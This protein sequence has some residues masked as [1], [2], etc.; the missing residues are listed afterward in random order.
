[1]KEVAIIGAG[2]AGLYL[3]CR[4]QEEGFQ[5][6]VF[7]KESA[8][9]GLAQCVPLEGTWIEKYYHHFFPNHDRARALVEELGL[10]RDL[11]WY[12]TRMGLY[13]KGKTYYF[14]GIKDLL[15]FPHHRS[16]EKIN[17]LYQ[18]A[19]IT[20]KKD[21]RLG[22]VSVLDFLHARFSENT[23]ALLWLPLLKMKFGDSYPDIAAA[24]LTTRI[25][26]RKSSQG[27][28][29][30]T[31]RLGYLK[32]GLH[33]LYGALEERLRAGQGKV[34]F[35]E[36]VTEVT[37][38]KGAFTVCTPRSRYHA[39]CVAV[40]TNLKDAAR[41]LKKLPRGGD[42]EKLVPS[43]QGVV[44]ALYVMKRKISDFYWINITD[45]GFPFLGF[46]E[47]TNMV[48]QAYYRGKSLVYV[49]KYCDPS[50]AYYRKD[51]AALSEDFLQGLGVL[52]GAKKEDVC[53]AHV[54]RDPY[55]QPVFSRQ[56]GEHQAAIKNHFSGVYFADIARIY[57]ESRSVNGA[58]LSAG[59]ARG[60]LL[61]KER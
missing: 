31:Q 12:D 46:I 25:S 26:D 7:E 50:S 34:F 23:I 21:L 38:A 42:F 44:C 55:A 28:L 24:F 54:F 13:A 32:G 6:S 45:D 51:D 49:V 35:N 8:A 17:F 43:Y 60:E 37:G 1:M 3:G 15:A 52:C 20:Q 47:H 33:A 10:G 40:T 39:S 29:K 48:P 18:L 11:A 53:A 61:A 58:I 5:V 57:P 27:I 4:L 14:C 59:K 30:N 2:I 41:F 36:P 9:G 16:T 22:G 56:F 19:R